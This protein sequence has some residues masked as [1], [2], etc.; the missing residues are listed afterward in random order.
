M[1]IPSHHIIGDTGH[2]A[3]HDSI[4]DV[5]TA[6]DQSIGDLETATVGLFYLAGSN[7]SNISDNTTIWGRVNLPAG[8]RSI[9]PDTF[10]V[11]HGSNKIFWI[12]NAGKPRVK[13]DDGTFIPWV[14]DSVTGHS[15]SLTEWRV[16]GIMK[17]KIDAAGNIVAPN[18]TPGAWTGITL[19][20]GISAYQPGTHQP[21]QYR[22]INDQVQ[23]RGTVTKSGGFTVS[24]VTLGTL[25]GGARPQFLAYAVC[26]TQFTGNKFSGRM[27]VN[28][29]GAIIFYFDATV[30]P[31]WINLDGMRFSIL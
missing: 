7:V 13:T 8:D 25:P 20:S 29:T 14:I 24:P 3:D 10:Q 1:P 16:N 18:T 27:E 21:P 2:T 30:S 28:N 19:Q 15:A 11:F 26:A 17:A 31:D 5:L 6:H 12:D 4:V 23:L 22:I 9:A